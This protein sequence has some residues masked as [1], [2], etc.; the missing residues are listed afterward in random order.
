MQNISNDALPIIKEIQN[1]IESRQDTLNLIMQDNDNILNLITKVDK[2]IDKLEEVDSK[3][4]PQTKTAN[5]ANSQTE[6]KSSINLDILNKTITVNGKLYT[7]SR[8]IISSGSENL[9]YTLKTIYQNV[10]KGCELPQSQEK[11]VSIVQ[12]EIKKGEYGNVIILNDQTSSPNRYFY[13]PITNYSDLKYNEMRLYRHH[14][15]KE[16]LQFT[17]KYKDDNYP[18]GRTYISSILDKFMKD[19]CAVL[20]SWRKNKDNSWT[21]YYFMTNEFTPELQDAKIGILQGEELKS[22]LES[23][24]ENQS[25]DSFPQGFLKCQEIIENNNKIFV[26]KGLNNARKFTRYY[27]ENE[28]EFVKNTI[29][30]DIYARDN[31]ELDELLDEINS[32]DDHIHFI[33]GVDFCRNLVLERKQKGES[34]HCVHTIHYTDHSTRYYY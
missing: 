7:F 5:Q 29:H 9:N 30:S 16:Y 8:E 17:K 6:E 3:S 22:E 31:D 21:R 11:C 4:I 13:L 32:N 24:K 20:I 23:I 2:K 26:Y 34:V 19:K 33:Q 10:Q 1:Q 14:V 18:Q 25:N 15:Y 27:Y 12:N 28:H